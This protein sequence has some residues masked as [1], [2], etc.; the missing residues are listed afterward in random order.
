[1]SGIIKKRQQNKLQSCR[2]LVAL[3][4]N[5]IENNEEINMTRHFYY[6]CDEFNNL[7]KNEKYDG[8]KINVSN[9][10]KSNSNTIY[11]I[12]T[13]VSDKLVTY[14]LFV[15]SRTLDHYP[16]PKNRVPETNKCIFTLI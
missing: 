3:L 12:S 6:G 15:S 8:I 5:S 2:S 4:K 9:Y 7:V 13:D 14:D 11:N 16:V 1:M 10:Y